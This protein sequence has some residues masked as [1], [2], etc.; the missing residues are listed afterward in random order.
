MKK[1]FDF[2]IGREVWVMHDNHIV[3]GTVCKAWCTKFI[4]VLD[5][6]TIEESECYTVCDADKK[7]IDSFSKQSLFLK[8]EDLINYLRINSKL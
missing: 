7:R 6:E 8:K 2:S 3:C 4:S 5:Y 1:T